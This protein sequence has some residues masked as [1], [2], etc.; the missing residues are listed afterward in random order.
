MPLTAAPLVNVSRSPSTRRRGG[1]NPAPIVPGVDS[2][3]TAF[4]F[5]DVTNAGLST[6]YESNTITVTGIDA[7]AAMTIT[8]GQYSVNGGAYASGPTTVFNGDSVKVRTTSSGSNSAGVDVTL[9]IGGVSDTYTVTTAAGAGA[10]SFTPFAYYDKTSVIQS[11]GAVS[12]WTDKGPNGVHLTQPTGAAQPTW[13]SNTITFDGVNDYLISANVDLSAKTALCVYARL[14]MI[15]GIAQHSGVAVIAS[16]SGDYQVAGVLIWSSQPTNL[17]QT[18]R[19][20][21]LIDTVVTPD[22][23]TR[24]GVELNLSGTDTAYNFETAITNTSAI[25]N[26]AF[27]NVSRLLLGGRITGTDPT[28]LPA[29]Y[30]KFS[31]DGLVILDFIPTAPQRDEIKAWLGVPGAL[32]AS[33]RDESG[34][35]LVDEAGNRLTG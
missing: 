1:S 28:A 21:T 9:T 22:T 25:D 19:T 30:A 32:L 5:T 31:I 15:T 12:Q 13:A 24:L 2:T 8:G 18:Y 17:L 34:N 14:T 4:T 10:F 29:F 35:L 27:S 11:G 7:P 20:G 6:V 3:P 33:L 23:L 26:A 16:P